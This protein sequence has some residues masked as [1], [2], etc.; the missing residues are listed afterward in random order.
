MR[1][2]RQWVVVES[3]FG[4]F[5]IGGDDVAVTDVL[6]PHQVVGIL[7]AATT[8]DPVRSGAAQL[9]EYFAGTRETFDVP[10]RSEGTEFQEAVWAALDHIP[11]GETRSYLWIADTIGRPRSARPAG[12]ALGANPIPLL[13]PCHRV[14]AT[15]GLGGYGG[16]TELKRSLL[17]LENADA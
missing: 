13:R 8:S 5:A 17:A 10:L 11:Y 16:G 1:G 3:S 12:Q 6:L 14:T 15:D 2:R 4:A 7:P 9:S